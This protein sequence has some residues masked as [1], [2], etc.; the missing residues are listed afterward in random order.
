MKLVAGRPPGP[1]TGEVRV[2]GDK[3]IAH[4]WLI[5]ACTA[6]GSSELLELPA[7]LD[8]RSTA[9][10]LAALL[11]EMRIDLTAYART[12]DDDPTPVYGLLLDG[13]GL[14]SLQPPEEPLY[15]GN[16][17]TT[18]RLLA[19]V[20]AGQA[21][22]TVLDGDESLRRRPM[23]RVGKPLRLMG[24][25]V[26]TDDG[27][28]PLTISGGFLTG[29]EY[30][31]PEPS[32]QV[33]GAVLLAGL[34]ADGDTAVEESVPTR[35][36][37]ERSLEALGAPVTILPR[38]VSIR[39]FQHPGFN[40]RIPGDISSAAFVAAAAALVPGSELVIRDV[41]LNSTRTEWVGHLRR[42]GAEIEGQVDH[43][44]LGEP[45]GRLSIRAGDGLRPL[46]LSAEET[47]QAIDEIPVLAALAA[48]A[49]GESRFAGAG[50][51]R[52]KESD[53]LAG[54]AEGLV[55]LGGEAAV[56][57]DDLIV[58][59][60]GLRGGAAG[61]RHDHR[62]VMAFTIAAL[63]AETPCT[64]DGAEWVGISYPEFLDDLQGLGA[65]VQA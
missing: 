34:Q 43:E 57:G 19:G 64:I 22:E 4:R 50:E 65:E 17:G 5:L 10:C 12:E 27:R 29:I 44:E 9:G 41:G 32:A 20:L 31:V 38:R 6:E 60:G 55:G 18:M 53:R 61:G 63:A 8:L 47:A 15:C 37:T 11:P 52:F 59:G 24:A 21:F 28:P 2:P 54:I 30:A 23:E 25:D 14:T 3:S 13:Q 36:H 45:V 46:H 35:D 48:H 33:K 7:S 42:M 49:D 62:L 1:L 40:V 26:R 39:A 16:S 56:Q 58:A 51:L